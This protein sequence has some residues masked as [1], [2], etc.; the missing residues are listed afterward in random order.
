MR[1]P[2]IEAHPNRLTPAFGPKFTATVAGPVP[3]GADSDTQESATVVAHPQ[4]AVVVRVTGTV[5]PAAPTSITV[6]DTW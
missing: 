5:P 3:A 2:S 4:A 1:R 6:G